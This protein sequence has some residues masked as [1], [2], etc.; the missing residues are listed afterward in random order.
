MCVKI[1]ESEMSETNV[2]LGTAYIAVRR[3]GATGIEFGDSSTLSR[4]LVDAVR[5]ARRHDKLRDSAS[6]DYPVVRFA[7]VQ[8][9]E[10]ADATKDACMEEIE[11]AM[12]LRGE[13]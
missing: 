1:K 2:D 12:G 11:A 5:S 6:S 13:G 4:Y 3:E 9:V 10:V 7:T 8:L